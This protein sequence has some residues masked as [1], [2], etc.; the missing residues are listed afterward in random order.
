MLDPIGV[1]DEALLIEQTEPLIEQP[2][3]REIRATDQLAVFRVGDTVVSMELNATPFT[4][5]VDEPNMERLIRAAHRRLAD[6][7]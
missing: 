1:G 7:R 4:P 6:W 5:V 2:K 3:N